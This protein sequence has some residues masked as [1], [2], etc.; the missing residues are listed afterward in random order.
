MYILGPTFCVY[1]NKDIESLVCYTSYTAVSQERVHKSDV[2]SI[3]AWPMLIQVGKWVSH[4]I[5]MI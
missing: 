1:G 5:V 4:S 3:V 2:S